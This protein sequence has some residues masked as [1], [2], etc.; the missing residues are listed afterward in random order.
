MEDFPLDDLPNDNYSA[1]ENM[2]KFCQN[3]MR[4]KMS[5]LKK[6]ELV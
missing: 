2:K 3:N 4:F 5:K 6:N 1:F